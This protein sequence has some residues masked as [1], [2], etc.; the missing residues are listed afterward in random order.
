MEIV[1]G[2]DLDGPVWRPLPPG[3][4]LAGAHAVGPA[5][6]ARLLALHVGLPAPASTSAR[7]VALLRPM[8]AAAGFWSASAAVD[9]LGTAEALLRWRDEFVWAGWQ[10]LPIS[11]RLDALF[12]LTELAPKGPADVAREVVDMLSQRR[13]EWSVSAT[14]EESSGLV[15]RLL[16][17][18]GAERS[19]TAPLA[20]PRARE[21][22]VVEPASLI[23]GAEVGASWLATKGS[24]VV[25]GREP[26]L[27]DALARAGLP[28]L[29]QSHSASDD[30]ALAVLPAVVAL[31]F[32]ADHPALAQRLL[33]LPQSPIHGH[34]RARLLAALTDWPSTTS[35]AWHDALARAEGKLTDDERGPARGAL[36]DIFNPDLGVNARIALV[37]GWADGRVGASASSA[38]WARVVEQCRLLRR[39]LVTAGP[40][41]GPLDVLRLVDV[42]T[43]EVGAAAVHPAEAGIS[44]VP[45]PGC[46]LGD[47][48]QL[49][50]WAAPD[51]LRTTPRLTRPERDALRVHGIVLPDAKALAR[52]QAGSWARALA[53]PTVGLLIIAPTVDGQGNTVP[54]P[55]VLDEILPHADVVRSRALLSAERGRRPALRPNVRPRTTWTVPAGR[56]HLRELESPNSIATL[57]SCSLRWALRYSTPVS[58]AANGALPGGPLLFGRLAHELLHGALQNHLHS[59]SAQLADEA[60]KLFDVDGPKLAAT[61]FLPGAD[62]ERAA[63]RAVVTDAARL[64]GQLMGDLGV[65]VQSTEQPL[66][67]DGR[68]LGT[69]FGGRPDLVLGPS[70]LL[71]LDFKWSLGH[72]HEALRAGTALQL[73]SYG[74]LV[75]GGLVNVDVGYLVL[76]LRQ[77]FST[78]KLSA[79]GARHLEGPSP[80]VTLGAL[81]RS[82]AAASVKLL[83]GVLEAPGADGRDAEPDRLTEGGVSVAPPCAFCE[84]GVLCGRD[85]CEDR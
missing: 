2:L 51:T 55:S 49:L 78:T 23:D 9:P 52:R 33:R 40:G 45:H 85:V 74:F 34:Y 67:D 53:A 32:D 61:L 26:L 7:S 29:G 11:D 70:P 27:D 20:T 50:W 48:D 81:Q 41:L 57:V 54:R 24:R 38:A 22:L 44:H 46:V 6:L 36:D 8:M 21:V 13:L 1:F 71:V 28:T 12:T 68:W 4:A 77:V 73:A 42:A 80:A 3:G 56:V 25:V 18:L 39:L 75:G 15:A 58:A 69:R 10:G 19:P 16:D 62:A 35:V 64:V 14:D 83:A 65:S 66:S 37:E 72:H 17:S 79:R 76:R 30:P 59:S 5:G 31:G 43:E 63:V 60:G 84:L 82:A 47:V